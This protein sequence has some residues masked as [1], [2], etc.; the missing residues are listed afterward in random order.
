MQVCL[1]AAVSPVNSCLLVQQAQVQA[2]LCA[3]VRKL[4]KEILA[5]KLMQVVVESM[6]GV[7]LSVNVSSACD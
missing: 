3:R 5:G 1:R 7:W 2:K 4:D 6:A